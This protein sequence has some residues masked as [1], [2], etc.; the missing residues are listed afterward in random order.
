MLNMIYD[1]NRT[2]GIEV[3]KLSSGCHGNLVTIVMKYFANAY[4]PKE[5]LQQIEFQYNLKRR[6][7]VPITVVAMAT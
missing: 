2:Q 4:C 6:S 7:Y 3:I 1:L 5:A